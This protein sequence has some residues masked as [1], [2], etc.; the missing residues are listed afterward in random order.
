MNIFIAQ[1]EVY[2]VPPGFLSRLLLCT[3]SRP[4]THDNPPAPDSSMLELQVCIVIPGSVSPF[5]P[6]MGTNDLLS[7][8]QLK[9][10]LLNSCI[11]GI[12]QCLMQFGLAS[13]SVWFKAVQMMEHGNSSF[14]L[15]GWEGSSSYGYIT[16][17]SSIPVLTALA[18]SQILA[19]LIKVLWI[20]L[21]KGFI[22]CEV[23]RAGMAGSRVRLTPF[24]RSWP[25]F[26][27][28]TVA[29]SFRPVI[30]GEVLVLPLPSQLL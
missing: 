3:P 19:I 10:S 25:L 24:F 26:S 15:Y 9:F 22:F 23:P 27:Q 6:T 21:H 16:I 14:V 29:A 7:S 8:P 13:C 30:E 17:S 2:C 28:V 12:F 18:C 4:Q 20:F 5:S 1:G 11:N